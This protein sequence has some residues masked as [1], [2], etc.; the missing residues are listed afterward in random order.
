MR[1]TEAKHSARNAQADRASKY[2]ELVKE[3]G[4]GDGGGGGGAGGGNGGGGGER[5][6]GWLEWLLS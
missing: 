5:G 1:K 6:K 3:R 2:P 4:E